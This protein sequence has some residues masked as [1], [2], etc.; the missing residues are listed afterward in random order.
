MSSWLKKIVLV[1]S[2]VRLFG[3]IL[4]ER[5]N[6]VDVEF[7][8]SVAERETHTYQKRGLLHAALPLQ[9]RI[10]L[11][12]S[13]GLWRVGRLVDKYREETGTY[14]YSVKFPNDD[15]VELPERDC[16][17]RCLDRYA[18][19][20]QILA[21]G[22]METQYYADRRRSALR[23]MRDLR[24]AAQGLVGIAS[25]SVELVPHQVATVRRVLNDR[26]TRYLLADEVGLG[27]TVEA[28]LI[29]RQL[30][31]DNPGLGVEV[32]VPSTLVKQWAAEL[33]SKCLLSNLD[34]SVRSH[35]EVGKLDES[36][37]PGMLVID[38]AHRLICPAGTVEQVA[39]YQKVRRLASRVPRI[40][41]LSATPALGDEERLLALLNLLDPI[42][43]PL[44]QLKQFRARVE[45]LQ[46]V[47]RLLLA[48]RPGGAAF[49]LKQQATKAREM[50]PTDTTVAEEAE[51]ILDSDDDQS[52]RDAAAAALKDHIA[53]TYRIHQRLI[54]TRRVDVEKWS[55]RP[56]GPA[57]PLLTNLKVCYDDDS[58]MAAIMAALETWR[59]SA[60]RHYFADE[61]L[62]GS[63]SQRWIELVDAT[64]RGSADL[65]TAA[66][67]SVP[68]FDGEADDLNELG[69]LAEVSASSNSRYVKASAEIAEWSKQLGRDVSGRPKKLVCFSSSS[70]DAKRLVR[71]LE[72]DLGRAQIVS[73]LDAGGDTARLVE[74]FC[75]STSLRVAVGDRDAEEGLNLQ[76]AHGIFHLNLPFD[77]ARLEQ[78][79]GRLDRFGRRLDRIEH[80]VLLP[81]EAD[82][83]PS[84]SWLS[85]LANGFQI[86][87]RSISDVQF[88]VDALEREI[89]LKLFRD[90]SYNIEELSA[91]ITSQI[92]AERERL[93]EQHALD[94][95][96]QLLESADSL[97][98]AIETSEEDEGALEKDIVPWVREVL[99][100]RVESQQDQSS[101]SDE[102][103]WT[104]DTL[105]PEVPWR[106]VFEPALHRR[107]TWRRRQSMQNRRPGAALLRP[108]SLLMEALE[109]VALWDDRGIAYATSRVEP[110]WLGIWRGF[111]LIWVIE[112]A[113]DT[114][115]AVY[116]RA[117]FSE[118]TR[119]AEAFLPSIT[120]EQYVLEDGEEV[121]DRQ[122]VEV[123][124]RPYHQRGDRS[125]RYDIN[126]GNRPEAMLQFIG[127]EQFATM[128][129]NA[130]RRARAALFEHQS[131]A[132]TLSAARAACERDFYRTSRSLAAR[133][134]LAKS[135]PSI[136]EMPSPEE[137]S[138]MLR[139]RECVT[140]PRARLDEIGFLVISATA[141][142]E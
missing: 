50:F 99:G 142:H 32:L 81:C 37:A 73:L 17:V 59:D 85:L 41:L 54:R 122:V 30:L 76:F 78:R 93:D 5:E 118:L 130:T 62:A 7:F 52:R 48:M 27:K 80:R 128:V 71:Q 22:C 43:Y 82:T 131:V 104:R 105:I 125:G 136:A 51:V 35:E 6:D 15:V 28:A 94:D 11:S 57:W 83:S 100:L 1:R 58:G 112:P 88:R 2:D 23:R 110:G 49:P 39:A 9:T 61:S 127:R 56:R 65:A 111:R 124:S 116:S 129:E 47:G 8:R 77:A 21:A 135:N 13:P 66:K 101:K 117:D 29:I 89:R 10:F 12:P 44:N 67:T 16:F 3:K 34:V 36:N 14:T 126:L 42:S 114:D 24:S 70:A 46:A 140:T 97:V 132:N 4:T 74:E 72:R 69:R 86:F 106:S 113:L 115:S 107:W 134:L 90:G 33:E 64:W 95:I 96:S 103:S 53:N 79:I 60:L 68:Q 20:S 102:V 121:K 91:R 120:V 139:L 123:L 75:R 109:R 87:N 137:T 55:M 45:S 84:S 31:L 25:A 138:D 141:A 63:L 92:N 18:D 108:G 40:L 119:R 19:P 26:K 38:E 98:H 133:T